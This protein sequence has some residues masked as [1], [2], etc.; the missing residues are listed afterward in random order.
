MY[1]LNPANIAA[2]A[3]NF[4]YKAN[5]KTSNLNLTR[6]FPPSLLR[7]S[8]ALQNDGTYTHTHT[9]SYFRWHL[10]YTS[11]SSTLESRLGAD[12]NVTEAGRKTRIRESCLKFWK[13]FVKA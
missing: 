4:V 11:G 8:V 1:Q 3:E 2:A 7:H 12:E 9:R 5:L 6:P 10:T 13:F